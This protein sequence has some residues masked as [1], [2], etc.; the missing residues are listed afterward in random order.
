MT[1]AHDYVQERD[2]A[3]SASR[4]EHYRKMYLQRKARQAASG[5]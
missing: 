5:R 4:K 2:R 3:R 1:A